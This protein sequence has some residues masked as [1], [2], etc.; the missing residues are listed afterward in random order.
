MNVAMIA[1]HY[2]QA[3]YRE[4]FV[5]RV[6]KVAE[7]FRGMPGCLSAECW[8]SEDAVV[9]IVRWES[10]EAFAASLAA[11]GT[12]DVDVAFDEREARPREIV[13]LVA[14]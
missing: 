8:L 7:A 12:A 6:R 10:D 9:S 1:K 13:R 4:E 14:A 3:A 2:P 11:L 5:G